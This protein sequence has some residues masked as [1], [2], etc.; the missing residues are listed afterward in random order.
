LELGNGTR[1]GH[2]CREES[3]SVIA[4][5]LRPPGRNHVHITHIT[6]SSGLGE[7]TH[8]ECVPESLSGVVEKMWHFEGRMSLLRERSF[9]RVYSEIILQLG[10]CFREVDMAGQ[11]KDFF[12]QA[13]F[14]GATTRPS[15]IEAP[16][17]VCWVIGI[18]LHA[19][20]ASL[21]SRAPASEVINATISLDDALGKHA[22][23]LA[24][25]CYD[26]PSVRARFD[27]VSEF[28]VQRIATHAYADRA[29]S[30]ASAVLRNS[31]GQSAIGSLQQA[32]SYSKSRFVT[33]FREQTGMT[34][35]QYARILRF[36][37]SLQLLQQGGRLSDA[38]L[39]AGYYDQAHMYRDFAEFAQMTPST[40]VQAERFPNSMSLP[41]AS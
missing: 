12:P 13:C 7:W 33:L 23:C 14:G 1:R 2:R 4:T 18:Q 26:A 35:K 32:T 17:A 38:A 20:G 10:P 29:I 16:D 40:W 31:N 27:L 34:P 11:S 41:E 36:R 6:H 15:V 37:N 24:E 5:R 22:H 19:A 25:R 3:A 8:S 21:L 39:M 28:I 9:P 30:W